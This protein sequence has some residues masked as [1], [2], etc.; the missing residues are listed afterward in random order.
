MPFAPVPGAVLAA[1][2]LGAVIGMTA[3]LRAGASPL[4][5]ML[6]L[7]ALCLGLALGGII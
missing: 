7:A 3:L 4:K 6:G 1:A 2:G 5:L